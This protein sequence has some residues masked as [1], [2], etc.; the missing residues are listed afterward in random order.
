MGSYTSVMND[1]NSTLY[2]KYAANHLGLQVAAIVTAIAGVI[3]AVLTG[4]VIALQISTTLIAASLGASGGA[5]SLAALV[6]GAID[7][8]TKDSGY[9]A[10]APGG[11]YRSGKLTLSLIHQ[12]DV[13]LT[14]V[15]NSNTVNMWSGSFTVVTGATAGSTKKYF[16]S[17]QLSKLDFKQVVISA[18]ANAA[19]LDKGVT[20]T[21]ANFTRVFYPSTGFTDK[22]PF[23]EQ[24]CA[25]ADLD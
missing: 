7:L 19:V 2:I 12:A 9:H 4:G 13:K 14:A 18:S 20:E 5:L 11:T 25:A 8:S 1:T 3:A 15:V 6:T 24:S 10:V 17:Q 22:F 21:F 23:L 16:M